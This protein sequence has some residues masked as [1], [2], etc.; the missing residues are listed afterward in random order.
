MYWRL[1][2]QQLKDWQVHFDELIFG[3]PDFD[4]LIDDK[5]LNTRDVD[6]IQDILTYFS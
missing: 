2:Y 1:T 5:A 3:K 4:L 6:S